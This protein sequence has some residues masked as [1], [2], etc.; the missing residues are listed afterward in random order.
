MVSVLRFYMAEGHRDRMA[1]G[2]RPVELP[3]A[4]P[5]SGGE[6]K[7]WRTAGKLS[8]AKA[9]EALGVGVR[10]V[11]RAEAAPGEAL[12]PALRDALQ[13]ALD[14]GRAT[15]PLLPSTQDHE[16]KSA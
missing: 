9:A 6:L 5:L 16:A 15:P 1:L 11:K 13:A 2:V 14:R 10:T 3:A 8:Q 12:G 4:R 7:I